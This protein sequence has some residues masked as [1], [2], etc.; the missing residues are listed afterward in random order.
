MGFDFDKYV[1]RSAKDAFSRISDD[2]SNKLEDAATNGISK[3]LGKG[4]KGIGLSNKVVNNIT[5]KFA[6]SVKADLGAQFYGKVEPVTE[7]IAGEGIRASRA[8]N[9]TNS[10]ALADTEFQRKIT[11]GSNWAKIAAGGA[12]KG[13][14]DDKLGNNYL[15]YPETPGL[16]FVALEFRKYERPNPYKTATGKLIETIFLPMPR[17][18]VEQHR[19]TYDA[20]AQGAPGGIADSL[21]GKGDVGESIKTA[22]GEEVSKII[23]NALNGVIEGSGDAALNAIQQSYGFAINPHLSVL[24]KGG[25]LRTHEFTWMFA[26]ESVQESITLVQ[27]INSLRLHSLPQFFQDTASLFDYPKMCKMKFYPFAYWGSGEGGALNRREDDLFIIKQSMISEIDVNYAP[28]GVPS[29]FAGTSYPTFIQLRITLQELEYH[30]QRDYG[31]A[32]SRRT[33][34]IGNALADIA[35]DIKKRAAD[36]EGTQ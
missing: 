22:A 16:Y 35:E 20:A 33:P 7:R 1:K 23:S 18:L 10:A 29:F 32:P 28:N 5:S 27:I 4:L 8:P 14:G 36:E 25:N 11:T 13:F 24:F 17:N 2:I 30:T 34:D 19:M 12:G 26:P 15:A 3:L 21:L 9:L 6:D 31:N